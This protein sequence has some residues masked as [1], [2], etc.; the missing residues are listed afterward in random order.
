[1]GVFSSPS[2]LKESNMPVTIN[3]KRKIKVQQDRYGNTIKT[4]ES[5]MAGW[6]N[7]KVPQGVGE[8]E[9]SPKE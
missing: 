2:R 4:E 6:R 3:I 5:G 8:T 1:V 7:D 9:E